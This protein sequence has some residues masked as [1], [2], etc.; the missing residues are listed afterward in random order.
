MNDPTPPRRP[1]DPDPELWDALDDGARLIRIL[2]DFY[3]RVYA[4]P[5]LRPFFEG[6]DP[7]WIRQKQYGFLHSK[8][9]GQDTYF[10][11]RPRNA[12]HWMVIS[13]EL[14]DHRL[15]LMRQCLRDAQLAPRLIER[16]MAYEEVFRKQIVKPAPVP[17]KV[18]GV[19]R[20]LEGLEKMVLEVG[21]L[22]DQCGE[23]IDQ[24]QRAQY[25]VRTGALYCA[26]CRPLSCS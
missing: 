13:N 5:Q 14:F 18:G 4:D 25:H 8:F 2:D 11:N 24:G 17:M 7:A 3:D 16:W 20:P 19:P 15:E 1:L 26:S 22:C 12:H 9:T 23:P 6:T 21:S 10:G